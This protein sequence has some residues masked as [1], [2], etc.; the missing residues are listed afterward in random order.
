MGKSEAGKGDGARPFSVDQETFATRHEATFGY[1]MPWWELR[2]YE[3]YKKV[4]DSGM[5][6]ELFPGLT[7]TWKEDKLRWMSLRTA[8]NK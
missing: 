1:K 6:F 7:G 5:F 8:S 2:D 4:L 3:E